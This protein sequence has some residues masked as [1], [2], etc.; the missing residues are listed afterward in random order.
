MLKQKVQ[1]P[2]DWLSW[3]EVNSVH[4]KI[5]RINPKIRSKVY[6][7]ILLVILWTPPKSHLTT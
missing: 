4:S 2:T 3:T 6:T 5:N 7:K 1:S